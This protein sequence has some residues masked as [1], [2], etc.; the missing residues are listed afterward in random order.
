MSGYSAPGKD[1]CHRNSGCA[2]SPQ[3]KRPM[4]FS[5][6]TGSRLHDASFSVKAEQTGTAFLPY[7]GTEL[8]KIFSQQQER[9][10]DND[11]TVRYEN[12]CLQIPQQ[13]FRFSLARCR[14]LVCRASGPD[15]QSFTTDTHRA[16]PL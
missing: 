1:V 7:P 9:V 15:H 4:S 5:A 8:E 10:I 11:N 6:R 12:R 14:V 3:L 2:A 13:T 16:G